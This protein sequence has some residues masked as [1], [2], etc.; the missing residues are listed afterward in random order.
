MG[1][2]DNL[3]DEEYLNHP[4]ITSL[5]KTQRIMTNIVKNIRAQQEAEKKRQEIEERKKQ[6]EAKYGMY[7]IALNNPLTR[8]TVM[9]AKGIN[10]AVIDTANMF[11][12]VNL[13]R[14]DDVAPQN[15]YEE[16][17][18]DASRLGY[19]G[20]A[21]VIALQGLGGAGGLGTG[22]SLISKAAHSLAKTPMKEVAGSA[23]TISAARNL[24]EPENPY[25]AVATDFLGAAMYPS[26]AN[27]GIA[28]KNLYMHARSNLADRVNVMKYRSQIDEMAKNMT[29]KD[30]YVKKIELGPLSKKHVDEL[31]RIRTENHVYEPSGNNPVPP[32]YQ[33]NDNFSVHD[34]GLKHMR[35]R[36]IENNGYSPKSVA[37]NVVK[38]VYNP[39]TVVNQSKKSIDEKTTMGHIQ[40]MIHPQNKLPGRV[41]IS[42]HSEKGYPMFKGFYQENYINTQKDF[43]LYK[44]AL[45]NHKIPGPYE[46]KTKKYMP[47]STIGFAT[48]RI[49]SS[50]GD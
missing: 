28:G 23:G 6:Y 37:T 50:I 5:N 48:A 17:V 24:V 31:N 33:Y 39:Y 45:E 27:L 2:Y 8:T 43:P 47:A 19:E 13:N 38:T 15:K 30:P 22:K 49:D 40:T 44:N 32:E 46:Y 12:G 35:E 34:W 1:S 41:F 18:K 14:H 26:V 42:T 29:V 20:A 25:T 10:D 4:K 9:A 16:F 3:T 21:E 7:D 36:R 11:S